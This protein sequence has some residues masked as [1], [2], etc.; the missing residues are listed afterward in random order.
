MAERSENGGGIDALAV[1]GL[2]TIREFPVGESAFPGS[3]FVQEREDLSSNLSRALGTRTPPEKT[4]DPI[5]PESLLSLV[6]GGTSDPKVTRRLSDALA[7][8]IDAADHFVA[9][10]E[11]VSGIEEGV[12]EEER[13]LDS[14]GAR[15]RVACLSELLSFDDIGIPHGRTGE[16][17]VEFSNIDFA[18]DC[19]F[20]EY[21]FSF[22]RRHIRCLLVDFEGA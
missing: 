3:K 20:P 14:F 18:S 5:R 10:L 6:E 13:V 4:G 15:I 22:A 1:P 16:G 7:F 19:A 11:E 2:D 8:H 9:D 12:G 17:E 21:H